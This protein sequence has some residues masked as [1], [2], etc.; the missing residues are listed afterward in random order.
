MVRMQEDFWFVSHRG[1]REHVLISNARK[2]V[3]PWMNILTLTS[4]VTPPNARSFN[5]DI[6]QNIKK[7]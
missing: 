4:V 2:A 5:T 7:S 6:E 3:P 1:A